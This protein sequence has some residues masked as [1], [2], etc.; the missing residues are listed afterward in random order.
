MLGD[1]ALVDQLAADSLGE[2][3]TGRNDR[4]LPG[5]QVL[6]HFRVMIIIPFPDDLVIQRMVE[7]LESHGDQ[8]LVLVLRR[9]DPDIKVRRSN[10][11][12][13]GTG[14]IE[15]LQ[16]AGDVPDGVGI[17]HAPAQFDHPVVDRPCRARGLRGEDLLPAGDKQRQDQ[18][19]KVKLFHSPIIFP[20]SY[21]RRAVCRKIKRL[22]SKIGRSCG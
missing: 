10:V 16:G 18:Q 8:F 9:K 12:A 2:A 1:V 13:L 19:P 22:S 6:P 11:H 5:N 4:V 3:E 21:G 20:Q 17:L 15:G 14:R 7:E